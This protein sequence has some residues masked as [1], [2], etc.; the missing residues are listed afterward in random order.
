VERVVIDLV[1][2]LAAAPFLLVGE[3]VT[4]VGL[5]IA[6]ASHLRPALSQLPARTMKAAGPTYA[7]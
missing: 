7:R 6:G 5:A 2:I 3:N 4:R 1:R